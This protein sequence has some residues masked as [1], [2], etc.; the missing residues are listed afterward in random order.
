M[1]R[2]SEKQLKELIRHVNKITGHPEE[3]YTKGED[4]NYHANVGSYTMA[5]AYGGYNVEQIV[6]EG[7][8]VTC[9]IGYGYKSKRELFGLIHAFIRGLQSK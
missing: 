3:A 5:A 7:G 8:G 2:I 9:P 1:D 6:N 4:G